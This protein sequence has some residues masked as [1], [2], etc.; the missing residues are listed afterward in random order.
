MHQCLKCI[1]KNLIKSQAWIVQMMKFI[2]KN[3]F[4]GKA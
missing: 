4:S 1:G 2:G 3:Q